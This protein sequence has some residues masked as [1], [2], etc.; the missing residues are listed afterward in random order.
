MAHM[1]LYDCPECALPATATSRGERPSTGGPVEHVFVRC[2][3]GH[4]FLG[5]VDMLTRAPAAE[6]A[7]TE[8]ANA[9]PAA[10]E[11]DA[12]AAEGAGVSRRRPAPPR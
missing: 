11:V 4:W 5:P 7:N 8:P 2:V 3:T 9:E 6:P 12:G 10:A 1:T